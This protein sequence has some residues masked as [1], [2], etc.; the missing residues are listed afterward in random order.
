MSG[1]AP[2]KKNIAGALI[3]ALMVTALPLA[4]LTAEKK[5][6]SENE[7]RVLASFPRL[8][9]ASYLDRSF[10]TGFSDY[11]SDHFIFREGFVK[12][13]NACERLSGKS[14][15]NGVYTDGDRMIEI[16]HTTADNETVMRSLAA[17][18]S[19]A[20]RADAPVFFAL[21]PTS[22]EIY[23]DSLPKLLN[24]EDESVFISACGDRL[25]DALA[26]NLVKPLSEHSGEYIYY[27]TDHHW[28]AAGAFVAY[29][30]LADALG[31]TPYS[32]DD[33]NIE[34]V[35]DGFRG[36]LFSKT[37]DNSI[38]PDTISYYT[39]KADSPGISMTVDDINK[40]AQSRSLYYPEKLEG[41][42]KYAFYLGSNKGLLTVR[43]NSVKAGR[44]LI[45]KDSY[46]NCLVPLLAEHYSEIT[47][48]DPRYASMQ[49]IL[50]INPGDY[51][52]ILILYNVIGFSSEESVVKLNF[53][54]K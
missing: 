42:D 13:K 20:R 17:V 33:F 19:L 7:N 51:S 46:A 52:Q 6:V 53:I 4:T 38:L 54:G 2:M 18:D 49:Q 44:L 3:F 45:I 50:S 25:T 40:Q 21:A 22:Q 32:E 23:K 31:F 37:L 15:I 28:T 14:E 9:L 1:G 29:G 43:N 39:L 11:L 16:L 27:R 36:T 35:S 10:M 34:Y 26:V 8:S 5:A 24:E 41:K 30:E 48:L 47:V 12:I